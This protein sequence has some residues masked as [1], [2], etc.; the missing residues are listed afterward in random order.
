MV[1]GW[2]LDRPPSWVPW[3]FDPG[4]LLRC[5]VVGEMSFE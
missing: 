4:W 3:H 1:G 5:D 2:G